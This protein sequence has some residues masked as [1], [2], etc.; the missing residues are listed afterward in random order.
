VNL[1]FRWGEP[2]LLFESESESERLY[3]L[4]CFWDKDL[5]ADS[6]APQWSPAAPA[7]CHRVQCTGFQETWAS[8]WTW[9]RLQ[10]QVSFWA[11]KISAHAG[12]RATRAAPLNPTKA[13]SR[14]GGFF[15]STYHTLSIVGCNNGGGGGNFSKVKRLVAKWVAFGIRKRLFSSFFEAVCDFRNVGTFSQGIFYS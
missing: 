8:R 11:S 13:E 6:S 7:T 14:R 15:R 10:V 1:P 12:P 3:T 5:I 2:A 4:F 9:A